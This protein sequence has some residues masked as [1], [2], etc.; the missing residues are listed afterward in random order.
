MKFT[1]IAGD[2]DGSNHPGDK[3]PRLASAGG[4]NP[5]GLGG[6]DS[7]TAA[8]AGLLPGAGNKLGNPVAIAGVPEYK[9][10]NVP[11]GLDGFR[12]AQYARA[13]QD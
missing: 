5:S 12:V 2:A 10:P 4:V 11:S 8:F 6:L 1:G 9:L 3:D 13:T 7:I